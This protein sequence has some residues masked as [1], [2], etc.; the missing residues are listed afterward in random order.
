VVLHIITLVRVFAI[1]AEYIHKVLRD[2]YTQLPCGGELF[3]ALVAYAVARLA[4]SFMNLEVSI[5]GGLVL[6]G[7]QSPRQGQHI[8]YIFL[9]GLT[10]QDHLLFLRG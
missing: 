3:P 5:L 8:S 2:V 10:G 6:A 7:G 4:T 9:G 1:W